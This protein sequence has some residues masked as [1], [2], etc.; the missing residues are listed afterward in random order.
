MSN[1]NRTKRTLSLLVKLVLS[2]VILSWL[3]KKFNITAEVFVFDSFQWHWVVIVILAW[4][5]QVILQSVRWR[6]LYG[7]DEVPPFGEFI[8]FIFIGYF[9]SILLPWSLGGDAVK[10][11]AFG[12]RH[13]GMLHSSSAILIGR[14]FGI[15]ALFLIFLFARLLFNYELDQ[16]ITVTLSLVA[17]GL[18][19]G[20][21]LLINSPRLVISKLP[22]SK[23]KTML[24][25][26]TNLEKKRWILGLVISIAIQFTVLTVIFAAFKMVG[27]QIEYS[28][29]LFY[30]PLTTVILF[31]P[32]SFSGLGV[33]E[34]SLVFFLT[35]F[36]GITSNHCMQASMIQY[37]SLIVLAVIGAIFFLFNKQKEKKLA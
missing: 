25:S 35:P 5:L 30:A 36:V 24:E 21:L 9:F 12:K 14:V 3:I 7:A 28:M 15:T 4:A 17:I 8:K 6:T 19:I 32:I 18:V 22:E 10:A 34:A 27:A 26:V 1:E 31:L 11:V 20:I 37:A 16:T 2:V 13:D 29:I 33:R 23:V